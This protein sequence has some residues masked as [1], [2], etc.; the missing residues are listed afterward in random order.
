GQVDPWSGD[1]IGRDGIEHL[2][3]L[4]PGVEL[5]NGGDIGYAIRGG[6]YKFNEPIGIGISQRLKNHSVDDGENRSVGAD[7]EGERQN[8]NERKARTLRKSAQ[9]LAAIRQKD[10]PLVLRC[11]QR[12]VCVNTECVNLV[13]K[14]DVDK[15]GWQSLDA[16]TDSARCQRPTRSMTGKATRVSNRLAFLAG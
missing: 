2:S 4:T 7:A 13:S 14:P 15:Q 6:P 1:I 11:R 5:R 16:M 9:A 12:S 10:L 3:L 8:G